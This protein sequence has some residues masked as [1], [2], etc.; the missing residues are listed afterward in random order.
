MTTQLALYN[1]A[2]R[3][4]KE[5]K[6]ASLSENTEARRVLDDVWNDG[7]VNYC[8]EQGFWNFATRT[9]KFTPETG[10][11]PAF[12][13]RNQFV[14]PSDFV[15]LA[16]MCQDEYFRIP[17][18]DYT[19]EAGNW[20]ADV[21]PLYVMYISNAPSYGNDL[22]RWPESFSNYVEL[23]LADEVCGRLTG[24]ADMVTNDLRKALIDARS[25]DAMNEPTRFLPAGRFVQARAGGYSRRDR[26]NRGGLIG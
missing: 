26:G 13:Y 24:D 20:Y 15:R 21:N 3:A 7:A 17:L 11:T 18:N 1:G 10:F 12:G 16:G 22:T 19:D 8:L 5:R 9:A 2:L 4:I 25:K 6:L 23:Y 14:K